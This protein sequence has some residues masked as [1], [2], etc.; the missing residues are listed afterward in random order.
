MSKRVINGGAALL[1]ALGILALVAGCGGGGAPHQN[2]TAEAAGPGAEA[3]NDAGATV[4]AANAESVTAVAASPCLNSARF[5]SDNNPSHA[6][7]LT[8]VNGQPFKANPGNADVQSS[9]KDASGAFRGT[10]AAT[11]VS[12]RGLTLKAN[13][14]HQKAQNVPPVQVHVQAKCADG[15]WSEWV[16]VP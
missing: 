8:G 1:P 12:A 9:V 16:P 5:D 13:L 10:T 14:R 4:E 3:E 2:G 15:Q 7:T 6:A 11:A